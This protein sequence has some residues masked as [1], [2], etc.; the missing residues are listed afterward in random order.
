[1]AFPELGR[2]TGAREARDPRNWRPAAGAGRVLRAALRGL[3]LR[4]CFALLAQIALRGL[5]PALRESQ[6]LDAEERALAARYERLASERG[7]G[8]RITDVCIFIGK[9]FAA[10]FHTRHGIAHGIGD[11]GYRCVGQHLGANPRTDRA[12]ID[13]D[14]GRHHINLF[15][16][17]L[18][19]GNLLFLA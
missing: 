8:V 13:A 12:F 15:T 10:V 7:K 18:G 6:V 4:V 5:R 19:Q 16:V 11:I 1:M 9:G 2:R 3:P 17:T 14:P